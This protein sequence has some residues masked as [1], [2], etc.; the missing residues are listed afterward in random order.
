MSLT[1]ASL[2][3]L[4]LAFLF[5]SA[6]YVVSRDPFDRLN[7]AYA[8][9]A[10]TLLAWVGT[11]FVFAA[12][13]QGATL[14]WLGRANFAAV[15]LVAP[16]VY[17]FVAALRKH[18]HPETYWLWGESLLLAVLALGTPFVDRAE[19][20]QG[21]VHVTTYGVLFPLYIVHIVIYLVAGIWGALRPATTLPRVVQS[22]L[23]LVGAGIL[24]TTAIGIITNAALPYLFGDFA[25]IHI[26]TVSTIIFLSTVAYAAVSKHLFNVQVVIRATLVF[27]L[28]IAFALE[29]YQ[30]S[31]EFLTKLLPLGD[32]TERHI[33]AAFVAL[34]INAF[35][36]EPLR[37]FC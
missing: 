30:A 11:L 2:Y 5:G 34:I 26:G 25:Y 12:Q 13:N 8:L 18:L 9:L 31:V 37:Q 28:L 27:G 14:L 19:A 22:Q 1:I 32:P 3:L 21:A 6:L 29:L 17:G 4:C 16:A 20:V 24:V 35:T 10:L 33:A 15:A 36:H 23:R 7:R